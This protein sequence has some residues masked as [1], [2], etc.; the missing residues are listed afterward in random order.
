[1]V[2]GRDV[3][4][5]YLTIDQFKSGIATRIKSINLNAPSYQTEKALYNKL[6]RNIDEVVDFIGANWGKYEIEEHEITGRA[7]DVLVP[8]G[9]SAPQKTAIER[10]VKYGAGQ[11]VT[12]NIIR[13]Q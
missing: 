12:V 7:F 2:H 6:R 9:G 10:A 5:G 13:H 1:M 8:H 4:F 11:G 3:P